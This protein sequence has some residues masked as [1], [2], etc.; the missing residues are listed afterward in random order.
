VKGTPQRPQGTRD[1]CLKCAAY[2]AGHEGV[3]DGSHEGEGAALHLH[4]L[5]SSHAPGSAP[6]NTSRRKRWGEV[7]SQL[8]RRFRAAKAELLCPLHDLGHEEQAVCARERRRHAGRDNVNTLPD[9][10]G[11]QKLHQGAGGR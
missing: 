5:N 7:E 1:T 4:V 6:S 3:M 10:V 9:A 2:L 8:K 11:G